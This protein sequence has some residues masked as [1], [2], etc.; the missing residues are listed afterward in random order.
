M[1]FTDEE[2]RWHYLRCALRVSHQRTVSVHAYVLMGNHVHMLL[3]SEGGASISRFMHDLGTSYAVW[4]NKRH[5]RTG[6]LWEGRFRS[7]LVDNEAYLWNCHRYIEFNPVRAGLCVHPL[8]HVWSSHAANARA[9]LDP[10]VTPRP[11]YLGLARTPAERAVRYQQLIDAAAHCEDFANRRLREAA[12]LGS[13]QFDARL[14]REHRWLIGKPRRG[15]RAK[16]APVESLH[17]DL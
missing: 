4:Y 13:E 12:T 1:V 6:T 2:D 3:G 16:Q 7:C 8:D 9:S 10:L 17:L 14:G 5:E 11:E 15:R